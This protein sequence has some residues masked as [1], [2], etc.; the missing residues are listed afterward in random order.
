MFFKLIPVFE[1]VIDFVREFILMLVFIIGFVVGVM[2]HDRFVFNVVV[3]FD[4]VFDSDKFV[5]FNFASVIYFI[6][7]FIFAS[8]CSFSIKRSSLFLFSMSCS[9]LR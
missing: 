2:I 8:P 1:S 5:V 7:L 9:T 6:C 4:G 3:G